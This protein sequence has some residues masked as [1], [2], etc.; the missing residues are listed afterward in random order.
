MFK[1]R[2]LLTAL[3]VAVIANCAYAEDTKTPA[4]ANND[5]N[6]IF[7]VPEITMETCSDKKIASEITLRLSIAEQHKNVNKQ[8]LEAISEY[9]D[10]C[11]VL[12]KQS[13]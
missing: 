1:T 4:T 2:Y 7:V 8:E 6:D 13:Q 12:L 11:L 5:N 10:K 9:A 3:C